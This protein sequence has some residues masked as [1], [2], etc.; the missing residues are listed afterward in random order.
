M[1]IL[2]WGIVSET[3]LGWGERG[4]GGVG[5]IKD[6][7]FDEV[8]GFFE[9][10]ERSQLECFSSGFENIELR[11]AGLPSGGIKSVP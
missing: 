8:S 4:I 6:I 2:G 10:I 11:F 1:V 9:K 5:G 3:G 7:S